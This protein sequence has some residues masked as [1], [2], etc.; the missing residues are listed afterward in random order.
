VS[1]R[2]LE[3]E[4]M[5]RVVVIASA[6]IGRDA[7]ESVLEADDE[8]HVLVPAV[9]QSRL[10][11]LT[12]AEDK[13]RAQAERVGEQ[14]GRDAPAKLASLEVKPD[15]PSQLVRDAIAEHHPDRIVLALREGDEATWLEEDELKGLPT[16]IDGVPVTRLAL[17]EGGD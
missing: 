4:L 9:E 2:G 1:V 10:A 5:A 13:A 12:S 7:L 15:S 6:E 14:I 17:T 3:A 16:D 11:W 8:L